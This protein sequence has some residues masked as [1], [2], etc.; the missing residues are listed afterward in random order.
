MAIR[1]PKGARLSRENWARAARFKEQTEFLGYP[2]MPIHD[3][4]HTYASLARSAGAD[5]KLLQYHASITVTAHTYADLF[6]SHLDRVA[7]ALDALNDR[8]YNLERDSGCHLDGNAGRRHQT[9]ALVLCPVQKAFSL[10]IRR[11]QHRPIHGFRLSSALG[12]ALSVVGRHV[13]G[14]RGPLVFAETEN[15]P[16]GLYC[17]TSSIAQWAMMGYVWRRDRH[18]GDGA[19]GTQEAR[20]SDGAE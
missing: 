17:S 8:P 1:S 10:F 4:R 9:S 5:L 6:D 20:H 7:D 19:S 12:S 18:G 3:L 11:S 13:V 14:Q 15:V 2:H 16:T